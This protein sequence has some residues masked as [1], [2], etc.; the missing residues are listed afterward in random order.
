MRIR[1]RLRARLAREVNV[2]GGLWVRFLSGP[3]IL[4]RAGERDAGTM[5]RYR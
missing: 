5:L 2:T 3:A 4:R 1:V